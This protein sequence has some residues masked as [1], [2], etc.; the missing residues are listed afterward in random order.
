MK[1]QFFTGNTLEQAVLAA[2]RQIG[3]EPERVAFTQRE[4]KHG[5]LRV[6]R[7]VVI[8]VDMESAV[9]PDGEKTP[10]LSSLPGGGVPS[11]PL[12]VKAQ[13]PRAQGRE[14]EEEPASEDF[15]EE[16]PP[17]SS[18]SESIERAL[19]EILR[20]L[21]L[22]AEVSLHRGEDGFEVELSGGDYEVLTH[23]EGRIL[24]SMEYLVPRMVRGWL[25]HGVPVK[26]DCGG[27]RESRAAE[28]QDLAA[29]VA[30]EVRREGTSQSLAP[31]SPADRR[32]VHLALAEVP[33]V[34]TE[35]EGDGYY[36]RVR[37][38]PIADELADSSE[39]D[40]F[41]DSSEEG[42]PA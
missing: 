37:I 29:R 13:A 24:Q 11:P 5:F 35:S 2:A 7:R 19:E 25:G 15:E 1:R 22:D 21:R 4:K 32:L 41:A 33:D 6:R 9:L 38:Y 23:G 36:K 8:E 16:A 28:L 26:V 30:E 27:F 14:V 12:L 10:D 17:P 39:V 40:G 34:E 42:V 31:M 18:E 3:V 20:F